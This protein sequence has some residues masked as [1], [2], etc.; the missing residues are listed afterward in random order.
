MGLEGQ[1]GVGAADDLAVAQVDAVEGADGHAAPLCWPDV[2]QA[3]DLH[4]V[5][6]Y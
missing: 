6:G 2:G 1:D 5:T 3:R 4:G